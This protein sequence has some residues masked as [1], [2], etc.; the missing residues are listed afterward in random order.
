MPASI[1]SIQLSMWIAEKKRS[2]TTRG[3]ALT[4]TASLDCLMV[5]ASD[6]MSSESKAVVIDVHP[7]ELLARTGLLTTAILPGCHQLVCALLQ[8]QSICKS[9]EIHHELGIVQS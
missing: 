9:K 2:K 7:A 8:R 1:K 4:L 5:A 3:M 6:D